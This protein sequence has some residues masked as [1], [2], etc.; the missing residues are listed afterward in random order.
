MVSQN[1]WLDTT[2]SCW[3]KPGTNCYIVLTPET[4]TR[5]RPRDWSTLVTMR[6]VLLTAHFVH[7]EVMK[8]GRYIKLLRTQIHIRTHTN[9]NTHIDAHH[10]YNRWT[11]T[12]FARCYVTHVRGRGRWAVCILAVTCAGRV[13]REYPPTLH[14][15]F[16]FLSVWLPLSEMY[17]GFWIIV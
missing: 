11:Y 17:Y 9:L 5:R 10:P 6:A 7:S 15:I 14:P 16:H 2:I 4:Y 12:Y 8:I 13:W 3:N 1:Q